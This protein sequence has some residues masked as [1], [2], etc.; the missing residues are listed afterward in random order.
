MSNVSSVSA[1][2]SFDFS[3]LKSVFISFSNDS[4]NSSAADVAP[5]IFIDFFDNNKKLHLNP[6]LLGI[7][8]GK[9]KEL[10]SLC[11]GDQSHLPSIATSQ[12]LCRA[13]RSDQHGATRHLRT[14]ESIEEAFK[15]TVDN[16]KTC[17]KVVVQTNNL[18]FHP[19]F[20]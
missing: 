13:P 14:Q 10:L 12:Q 16:K 6:D 3:S 18:H 4:L 7:L 8:L 1:M 15:E 11:E 20:K 9:V 19:N 17:V 2:S 5:S